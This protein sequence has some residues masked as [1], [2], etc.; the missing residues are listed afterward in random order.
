M[1][2]E[3]SDALLNKGWHDQCEFRFAPGG[4]SSKGTAKDA[5]DFIRILKNYIDPHLKLRANRDAH[6]EDVYGAAMQI[7]QDEICEIIDPLLQDSAKSIQESSRQFWEGRDANGYP[8]A[9]ARLAHMGT[10]LIHWGVFHLLS[11]ARAPVGMDVVNS[12]AKAVEE[13]DIFTVNHDLLLE[14]QLK[15]AGI[16]FTDGFSE[17]IG[18]VLRFNWSWNEKISVRL[19][20]LHGSLDWYQF[21]FPGGIIQFGKVPTKCD[22]SK[23]KDADGEDLFLRN[24]TPLILIGTTGKERL[25]GVGFVGEVFLQFHNRL[26]T[27]HTLICCGYGWADTGINNRVNQWLMNRTENRVIILHGGSLDELK[28][29]RFWSKN[30]RWEHFKSMGKVIVVPKWLSDCTLA[31]LERFFDK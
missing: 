11:P 22:P 8:N 7:F 28:Q 10:L 31:D 4:D 25:Y 9:F 2:G 30:N 17:K 16:Q 19:Y 27:Y 3:I 14:N 15:Q 6:Y 12:V 29:K 21:G 1:V 20:K 23:C 18:D 26:L 24:P 13:L 5:Q